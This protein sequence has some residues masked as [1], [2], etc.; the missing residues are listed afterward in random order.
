MHA[1]TD[2]GTTLHVLAPRTLAPVRPSLPVGHE[3]RA[4]ARH[5]GRGSRSLGGDDWQRTNL[6]RSSDVV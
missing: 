1:I 3:P 2:T 4:V 5:P 6:T